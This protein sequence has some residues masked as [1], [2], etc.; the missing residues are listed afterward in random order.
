MDDPDLL[1]LYFAVQLDSDASWQTAYANDSWSSDP[2]NT[3]KLSFKKEKWYNSSGLIVLP[4]SLGLRELILKE[5]HDAPSAGHPGVAKTVKLITINYWWPH[6]FSEV[7]TYIKFCPLCQSNK[8]V[9]TKK[10]GLLSPVQAPKHRWQIVGM[11]F[12]TALPVTAR[13]YSAILVV[14]DK[15]MKW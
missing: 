2:T 8:A 14:I 6:M 11:D 10:A 3:A 4:N 1:P 12:V 9:T 13:G 5:C 7:K 15:L